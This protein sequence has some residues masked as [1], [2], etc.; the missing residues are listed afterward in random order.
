MTRMILQQLLHSLLVERSFVEAVAA[1]VV[2]VE[3]AAA[4]IGYV[5]SAGLVDVD[6]V[7]LL[8]PSLGTLKPLLVAAIAAA[9]PQLPR[10]AV[11]VL[12]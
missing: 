2:V 5:G 12:E 9:V 4:G 7:A 3:S 6:C 10:T 11:T 1:G 8:I